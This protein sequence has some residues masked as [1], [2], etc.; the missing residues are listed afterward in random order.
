MHP[1]LHFHLKSITRLIYFVTEEEDRFLIELREALKVN[2][3]NAKVFNA[4]FGLIQLTALINDWKSKT[5]KVDDDTAS[6]T[7]ALTAIYKEVTNNRKLY[8]VLTDPDR[9]LA[10]EGVQRRILNIIHQ[11]HNDEESIKIIICVGNQ[12]Y[13]PSKLARYTEVVHDTGLNAD[14]ILSVVTR[15]CV[16]LKLKDIPAIPETVFRG[17]T[18]FEIRSALIQTFKQTRTVDPKLLSDYRFRQLKKTDLVKYIDVSERSFEQVGGIE[19]F[20]KWALLAKAAWSPEGREYGLEPPKGILAVGIWGTGKSLS[21]Q[22]LGAVWGLPVVQL[23]MGMMRSS[24][25]GDTENNVYRAIRV[26]EMMAPCVTGETVVTLEDGTTRPI[27]D[28]WQDHVSSSEPLTVQCWNERTLKVESTL[29]REVTRR[30]AEAFRIEAANGFYLGATA[31]HWHYVMRGGLPE[32]VRTDELNVG[33]ML[34]VPLAVHPGNNDCVRFH[35]EGMREYQSNVFTNGPE[36]RRGGGGFRDAVVPK[37][38]IKWSTDLGWLLGII[39]GDGFI[40]ARDGIGLTNTSATLLTAFESIIRR[41][42]GLTAVRR[43]TLQTEA[44]TI[45][46]LPGLSDDP[47]FQPCWNTVVT[48]Q[49][50]AEFLRAARRNI[51]SAP[52]PVRAAFL[53]GWVDADGCVGPN[54]ITL[55]V[56]HPIMWAHRQA[57]GRQ[58]VQ[59]LGVTPSKFDFPGMEV[60][61]PRAV[62]L[63]GLLADHLVSKKAKAVCVSS[64]ETGFDRGMG[65]HC[66][67][68]LHDAR[69]ASGVKFKELGVPPVSSW[70]H[71]HGILVSE[72]HMGSY[73]KTLGNKDLSRLL[74]AECRW[75]QIRSISSIGN[76]EVYDLVCEGDDTHSFFANGLVTHNCIV[77]VDE[78]EKS[79]SGGHSSSYSDAGTTS[80]AIGILST[81]MQETKAPICVAMTANSLKTLPVEFV[82]RMDERWFFDLPS[83]DDRIDILKIHLRKRK[84]PVERFDL[85]RLAT[86]SKS[87]VGR[88]IEQCLKA[89]MTASFVSDPTKGLNEEL[90]ITEL[91]RKPRI[92]KT[93]T[94]EIQETLDWV[95][96]D[97]DVDDG[98]RARFAAD[99]SGQERKFNVE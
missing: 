65:F 96:Y 21:I 69:K 15:T 73:V 6:I 20:K 85:A 5:H 92:I 86:A 78:A 70:Q 39:E 2:A 79:L 24:R 66:G 93:M 54:K 67:Q 25:V 74:G 10:D 12:R 62:K 7:G 34:A 87:L 42:F 40:G 97:P 80:R 1:E 48:N 33:D 16:S 41:L 60:T 29:V 68:L 57:L 28:L 44:G 75:V 95:G 14:E 59:S 71:E 17:L 84:Q 31:N 46:D 56:K 61:G 49:L 91:T 63:A 3:P 30:R 52:P 35:P 23:E 4:A 45:P 38:P 94:D 37:L 47:H 76:Q 72:R 53:A 90:F 27:A 82:N 26:I 98:V 64:S 50:A 89:A 18:S 19:R 88:E 8:Y 99:P 55:T 77:W 36:W 13:V 11:A 83:H 43:P 81:W 58:L 32:W 22:T 51:L 9:W